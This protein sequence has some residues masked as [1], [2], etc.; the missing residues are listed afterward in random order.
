MDY[1]QRECKVSEKGETLQEGGENS[2]ADKSITRKRGRKRVPQGTCPELTSFTA[3]KES[4]G[5]K[6]GRYSKA[7]LKGKRKLQN[8]RKNHE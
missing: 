7:G 3:R 4:E 5:G 8:F 2:R 1:V 6:G